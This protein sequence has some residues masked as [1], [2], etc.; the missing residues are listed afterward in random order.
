[1]FLLRRTQDQSQYKWLNEKK[2]ITK[3]TVG[4][5]KMIISTDTN[6][7]CEANICLKLVSMYTVFSCT[8]YAW[9]FQN[10]S[11]A[12]GKTYTGGCIHNVFRGIICQ[13]VMCW[14]L[15][16][17]GKYRNQLTEN[18]LEKEN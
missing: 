9:E 4:A 11:L 18:Y 16:K 17:G 2:H 5:K 14:I 6:E 12:G 7:Y 1:M 3:S 13:G 10:Y 8:A 15:S